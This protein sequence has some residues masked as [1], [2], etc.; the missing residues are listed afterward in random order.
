MLEMLCDSLTSAGD[1]KLASLEIS[2]FVFRV[3]EYFG[4]TLESL[5]ITAPSVNKLD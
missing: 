1:I 3:A 4:E 5:K 2:P